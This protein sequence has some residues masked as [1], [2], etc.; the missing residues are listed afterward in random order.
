MAV[1]LNPELCHIIGHSLGAHLAGYA[2]YHLRED[3]GLKLGRITGRL[4]DALRAGNPFDIYRGA[5]CI[6]VLWCGA[7]LIPSTCPDPGGAG[8]NSEQI[9]VKIEISSSRDGSS[10]TSLQQHGPTRPSRSDGCDIR[11]CHS[12]RC[13]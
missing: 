5:S 11:R 6:Q 4:H 3:F 12:H 7:P 8:A 10:T 1:G 13:N 2:G 9:V